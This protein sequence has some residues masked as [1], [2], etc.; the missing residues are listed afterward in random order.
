MGKDTVHRIQNELRATTFD[1]PLRIILQVGSIA[2]PLRNS[3][4][5]NQNENNL[6]AQDAPVELPSSA[7]CFDMAELV[8]DLELIGLKVHVS[9]PSG[10]IVIEGKA[11]QIVQA[12]DQDCVVNAAYD[13]DL[14]LLTRDT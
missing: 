6:N 8:Q 7:S 11:E 12:L 13:R 4:T 1:G 2:S 14:S 9:T 3:E 10:T 5:L